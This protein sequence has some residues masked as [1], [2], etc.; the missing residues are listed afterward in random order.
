MHPLLVAI[1]NSPNRRFSVVAKAEEA[2]VY[3][4]DAIGGYFGL[5]AAD[6]VREI[7]AITAPLIHVRI[8]SPGGDVFEAR[9]VATVLKAHAARVVVHVDGLAAS[10]ATTIAL[11]GDEVR[12]ATGAFFMIHEAWSVSVGSAADHRQ[13]ADLVD[14]VNDAI[15]ADYVAKTGAT[16]AQ[17]RTWMAAESWFTAEEAVA[18]GFADV[19]SDGQATNNSW[20]L[21]AAYKN[22]PHQLA[23]ADPRPAHES[24]VAGGEIQHSENLRRFRVLEQM[25]N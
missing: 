1:R 15:V 21:A 6:I 20:N 23:A 25:P 13:M 18:N 4:Y 3:L 8:N 7:G 14:K 10:A 5:A 24:P 11:A 19:I 9:A 22:P 17:V 2:T 16:E 12:M